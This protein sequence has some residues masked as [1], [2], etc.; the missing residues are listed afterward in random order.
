MSQA[1]LMTEFE[2]LSSRDRLQFLEEAI[3]RVRD[4]VLTCY[5]EII[6]EDGRARWDTLLAFGAAIMLNDYRHDRE[7]TAVTASAQVSTPA[8]RWKSTDV[9]VPVAVA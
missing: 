5:P 6:A 9:A 7:L 1:E 4:D 8:V 3:K 2:S